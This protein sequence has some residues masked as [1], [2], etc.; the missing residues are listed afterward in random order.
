MKKSVKIII[1]LILFITIVGCSNVNN[2]EIML[3]KEEIIESR[4]HKVRGRDI[5]YKVPKGYIEDDDTEG[6]M[7][8]SY[9]KDAG[10]DDYMIAV[11]NMSISESNY[12]YENIEELKENYVYGIELMVK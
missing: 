3:E 10:V 7:Y 1:N 5:K 6:E 4:V 2:K 9:Y 11:Y 8:R 12:T